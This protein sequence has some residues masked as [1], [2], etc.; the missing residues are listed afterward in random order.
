MSG[1]LVQ[2]IHKRFGAKTVLSQVS[3]EL[4]Q[5]KCLAILGRSGSG[6]SVLLKIISGIM[7]PDRGHVR[8]FSNNVSMVFQNNALFD[9]MS[10]W[11][12]LAFPLKER[13]G[14]VGQ[15]AA[16]SIEA[17][18]AAVEL[19]GNEDKMPAAL[20]G[21]MQKRLAIARALAARPDILL[22]DEPTAGL[23]P[24][25]SRIIA[26]LIAKLQK[27][28]GTTMVVVTSD[29]NRAVQLGQDMALLIPSQ[30]G[31]ATMIG[32]GTAADLKSNQD[33]NVYQFVRGL[34][35]GPLTIVESKKIA[36]KNMQSAF[37]GIDRDPF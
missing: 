26:E 5:H 10:V 35:Q 22:Y 16:R 20:S 25:T 12:N 11:Q 8:C 7:T 23:D 31:G 36:V 19:S 6:K 17:L 15:K 30:G 4:D 21:G 34:Q 24:I 33:P 1:I 13:H 2:N 29:V 28:N 14:I 3:F 37:E 9:S 32:V 18:L 27:D